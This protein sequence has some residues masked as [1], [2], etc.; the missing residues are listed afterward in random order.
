MHGFIVERQDC[1]F[2]FLIRQDYSP[3]CIGI[4]V[5][6]FLD[7]NPQ[8]IIIVIQAGCLS[9]FCLLVRNNSIADHSGKVHT[10]RSA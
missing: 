3:E 2:T 5:L 6:F 7:S 8:I 1:S 9:L 4:E 10:V